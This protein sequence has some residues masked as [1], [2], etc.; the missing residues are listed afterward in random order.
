MYYLCIIY[1]LFYYILCQVVSY[2]ILLIDYNK[3]RLLQSLVF[4]LSINTIFCQIQVSLIKEIV[5]I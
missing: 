2:Y 3:S 1:V 4:F 5:Y